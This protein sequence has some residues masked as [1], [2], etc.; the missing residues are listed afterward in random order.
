MSEPS[1]TYAAGYDAVCCFVNDDAN[2]NVIQTL[3]LVGVKCIAMRCAGFD[4]VDTR[5][6]TAYGL[7]VC[8]V[9]AYSPY[10]VAE[11]AIA[12]RM[13]VNRKITKT[14]NRLKLANFTLD[15][16]L[17]GV[18]IH[19]KTVGRLRTGK[20]RTVAKYSMVY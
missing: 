13:A 17:M 12:L 15:S 2:S 14:S 4:R 6:A 7:T 5:A 19:G 8:R 20:Y 1:A 18:D 9:P 3:S 11:M 10:D 16:R